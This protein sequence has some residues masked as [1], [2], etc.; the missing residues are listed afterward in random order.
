MLFAKNPEKITIDSKNL[1]YAKSGVDDDATALL[2]YDNKFQGKIHVSIKNNLDNICVIR[3]SKGSLKINEPWK[4]DTNSTIEVTS[5]KHFYI[6]SIS[7]KL[8]VYANQIERVAESFINEKEN[9]NLFNI[10]KSLIN[11]KLMDN[12]LKN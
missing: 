3:G 5:K 4:P 8:T 7:S 9:S 6:K 1:T 12:W 10:D 2:N 11:M